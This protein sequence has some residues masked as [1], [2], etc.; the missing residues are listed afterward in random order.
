MTQIFKIKVIILIHLFNNQLISAHNAQST[1]I[2]GEVLK[3]QKFSNIELTWKQY[4]FRLR[5][6]LAQS[7]QSV[8][9]ADQPPAN[10]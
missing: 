1:F 7:V 4:I 2:L 3:K 5:P 9:S 10:P 8:Q 6:S